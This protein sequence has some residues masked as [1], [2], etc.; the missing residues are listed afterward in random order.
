M[1][2]KLKTV[3][4]SYPSSSNAAKFGFSNSGCY[5]VETI[6]E[7]YGSHSIPKPVAAFATKDEAVKYAETLPYEWHPLYLKYNS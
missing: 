2:S 1:A 5:T 6:G 4:Y 7:H 3:E